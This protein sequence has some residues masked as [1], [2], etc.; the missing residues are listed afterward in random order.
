M[1][2]ATA[3]SV[4]MPTRYVAI[5]TSTGRF[6]RGPVFVAADRAVLS[7][8]FFGGGGDLVFPCIHKNFRLHG[9]TDYHYL[10]VVALSA[11]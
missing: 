10:I 6:H 9:G 4:A 8:L 1:S 3:G 2:P 11:N 7:A 5:T